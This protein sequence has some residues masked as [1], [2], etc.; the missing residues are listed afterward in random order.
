MANEQTLKIRTALSQLDP[1]NNDHWTDDG[2][3]KTAVV[4]RLAND[5]TIK[6]QDI[7][8]AQPGF[9]RPAPT[10]EQ[11]AVLDAAGAGAQTDDFGAPVDQTAGETKDTAQV[12]GAEPQQREGEYLSED[13]VR[14][15][16][17]KR[18]DD[19][20]ASIDASRKMVTDG[21]NGIAAGI[22]ALRAAQNDLHR[23][24]PP[25]T[26][27]ENIKQHLASENARRA[28]RANVN[29]GRAPSQLD[30]AYG[31]GNSRG[32]KRSVRGVTGADGNLIKNADGSVTMPVPIQ[33]SRMVL[34]SQAN[35]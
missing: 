12:N 11:Q 23:E 21:N 9:E 5:Q 16:L 32:W 2:L 29:G 14:A 3:P 35:R 26:A 24:F 4:Q 10:P 19:A 27:A 30:A 20:Q 8:N 31:R 6:R 18:I 33:R 28:E 7:Q 22:V 17:Q 13:E 1:T 25:L 15:V 34:P